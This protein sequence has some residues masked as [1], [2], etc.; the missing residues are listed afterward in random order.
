MV[1]DGGLKYIDAPYPELYDL[2]SDPG[3][4]ANLA[5]TRKSEVQKFRTRLIQFEKANARDYSKEQRTVTAEEAEQFAAIGYLGGQI[6]ESKW[7]FKKRSKG[8]YR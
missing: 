1:Q 5:E 8:F 4:S 6:P 2:A 7:D 3:E